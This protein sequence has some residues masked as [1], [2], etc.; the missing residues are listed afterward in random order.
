M[1]Q[2][3]ILAGGTSAGGRGPLG[4]RHILIPLGGA[5]VAGCSA[6]GV[7]HPAGPINQTDEIEIYRGKFYPVFG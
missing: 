2:L 1:F 5:Q 6:A 3:V 4:P 7:E